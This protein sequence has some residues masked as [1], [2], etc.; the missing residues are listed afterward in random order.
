MHK[1][2]AM[3][4]IQELD[5]YLMKH[6]L[7]DLQTGVLLREADNDTLSKVLQDIWQMR[8]HYNRLGLIVADA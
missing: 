2:K 7:I 4:R 8:E 5:A 1:D 3:T 6:I